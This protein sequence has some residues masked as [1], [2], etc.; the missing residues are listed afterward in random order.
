MFIQRTPLVLYEYIQLRRSNKIINVMFLQYFQRL[1]FGKDLQRPLT[2]LFSKYCSRNSQ[3]VEFQFA[4]VLY[5]IMVYFLC[6]THTHMVLMLLNFSFVSRIKVLVLTKKSQ[7]N[8]Y[9]YMN[10]LEYIEFPNLFQPS[11]RFHVFLLNQFL[12]LDNVDI[13]N[14]NSTKKNSIFLVIFFVILTLRRWIFIFPYRFKLI[15]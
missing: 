9:E 6:H 7:C 2:W 15:E 8:G 14:S 13:L 11:C 1:F 3:N 10:Q 12:F 5:F 4:N